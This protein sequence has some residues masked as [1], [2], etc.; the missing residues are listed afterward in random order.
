MVKKKAKG[1]GMWGVVVGSSERVPGSAE[2]AGVHGELVNESCGKGIHTGCPGVLDTSPSSRGYEECSI[3]HYVPICPPVPP[4]PL[5]LVCVHSLCHLSITKSK[6]SY[7]IC[8]KNMV[9]ALYCT[10][11][12]QVIPRSKRMNYQLRNL[13]MEMDLIHCV[14]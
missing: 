5:S 12:L 10:V 13:S 2:D 14:H 9:H 4:C 3:Y 8:R 1:K 7:I 6:L 11:V